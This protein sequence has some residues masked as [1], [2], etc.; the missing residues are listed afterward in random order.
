MALCR[1]QPSTMTIV[2]Q[3]KQC[4]GVKWRRYYLGHFLSDFKHEQKSL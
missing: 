1:L 2:E 3:A 4:R